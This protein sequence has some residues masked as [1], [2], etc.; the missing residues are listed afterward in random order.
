MNK[1]PFQLS[2]LFVLLTASQVQAAEAPLYDETTY[3][4]CIIQQEAM[5]RGSI[6]QP[7]PTLDKEICIVRGVM[8]LPEWQTKSLGC[9]ASRM[10]V[11]RRHECLIAMEREVRELIK[12]K[13]IKPPA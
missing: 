2:L 10:E 5:I 3:K 1:K 6:A 11:R 7:P 12:T 8:A 4:T 13:E 9:V